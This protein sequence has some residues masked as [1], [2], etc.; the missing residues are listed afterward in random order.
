[1]PTPMQWATASVAIKAKG[2]ENWLPA[3]Q[4]RGAASACLW[5]S[6]RGKKTEQA[7]IVDHPSGG[8]TVGCSARHYYKDSMPALQCERLRR[9][10][11][12]TAAVVYAVRLAR[13]FH[14]RQPWISPPGGR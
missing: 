6:I 14:R 9:Y 2:W 1:M 7:R 11:T 4:N 8:H 13:N 10:N 12:F 5:V 3:I